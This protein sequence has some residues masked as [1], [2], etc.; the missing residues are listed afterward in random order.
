MTVA[1]LISLRETF[2]ASLVVC[3]VLAFL[4]RIGRNDFTPAVWLGV[5]GGAAL[6]IA[7]AFVLS[8]F[9]GAV[10]ERS[11]AFYEGTM[12][13]AAAGL[14]LWMVVWMAGAGKTMKR[15]IEECAAT[16]VA[17][18]SFLGIF[19]IS[20]TAAAREGAEMAL[21][22]HA[23]MLDSGKTLHAVAGVCM[24]VTGAVIIAAFLIR[25]IRLMPMKFF[26]ALTT[27]LIIILGSALAMK[28]TE[29]FME[30]IEAMETTTAH[31]E[32]EESG[33]PV[34][35]TGLLYAGMALAIWR[36]RTTAAQ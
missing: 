11:L 33:L 16:H 35:G 25:G 23:T 26:F 28:G 19:L 17:G 20:F 29:E 32:A 2:E 21:M 1:A 5:A 14:V 36:K 27:T 31:D 6:S 24:G 18:G 9:A 22:V 10:P 30:G 3:V 15:D 4:Q 7:F 13:L 8:A 34:F 12:Y